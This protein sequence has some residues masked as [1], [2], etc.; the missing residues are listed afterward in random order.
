MVNQL[1]TEYPESA[2]DEQ[3]LR[4]EVERILDRS[5]VW[6]A[7]T[8]L[9]HALETSGEVNGQVASALIEEAMAGG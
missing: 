6:K 7:V 5:D 9:A 2:A 8:A 4:R 1:Q 3:D